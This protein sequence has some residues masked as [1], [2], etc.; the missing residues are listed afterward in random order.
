MG[1]VELAI[2]ADLACPERQ[3]WGGPFP[4][5]RAETLDRVFSLRA[6]IW[7]SEPGLVDITKLDPHALRDVHDDHG[8][9]W[10]IT[11]GG[12]IVAAA[13]M[14]IHHDACELPYCDGFG[15]L[16]ADLPAPIASL[17]RMVVHPSVRRQGLTEP[18]TLARIAMAK[19]S[20]V[21][22]IIV[23]AAPNRV[24]PLRDLGFVALGRSLGQP[25]DRVPFTLM[26]LDLS[27]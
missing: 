9:H 14:C 6:E 24:S 25:S 19:R 2:S 21:R 20:G 1:R 26:S 17:N 5:F 10:I 16:V 23:E 27:V 3:P 22:T 11:L 8:H 13:R 18:L 15:H 4:A 7:R 12:S